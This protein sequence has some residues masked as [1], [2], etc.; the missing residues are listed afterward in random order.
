MA[1][2]IKSEIEIRNFLEADE[3]VQ[4]TIVQIN[5]DLGG[6]SEQSMVFDGASANQL[7]AL[8]EQMKHILTSVQNL[9]RIAQFIY[10]VDLNEHDFRNALQN[11]NWH[12]LAFLVICREAQKVFLRHHFSA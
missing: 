12:D 1:A 7:E 8:R 2:L 6:I 4:A 3:F 10:R 5:K 9:E 11:E